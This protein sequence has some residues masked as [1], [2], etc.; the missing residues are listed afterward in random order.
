M[1][2]LL[3]VSEIRRYRYVGVIVKAQFVA[4][5]KHAP[6]QP[7]QLDR[8]SGVA[9]SVITAPAT[10]RRKPL[11]NR[12]RRNRQHRDIGRDIHGPSV[13]IP[14]NVVGA[15]PF[16]GEAPSYASVPPL[17]SLGNL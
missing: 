4:V 5:P 14:A 7:I 3:D 2:C 13:I 10:R 15:Q 11:R 16:S 1:G 8:G 17:K 6:P 9:V 12:D